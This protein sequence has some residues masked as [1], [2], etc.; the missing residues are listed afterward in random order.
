METSMKED[1]LPVLLIGSAGY[2]A[3]IGWSALWGYVL[4][5]AVI[6]G[7]FKAAAIAF[8]LFMTAVPVLKVGDRAFVVIGAIIGSLTLFYVGMLIASAIFG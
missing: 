4:L 8:A 3:T 1:S 7:N 5:F 2:I 6:D